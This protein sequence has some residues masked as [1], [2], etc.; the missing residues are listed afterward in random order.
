MKGQPGQLG[1]LGKC[2]EREE[3]DS[4]GLCFH[5]LKHFWH[6]SAISV[7]LVDPVPHICSEK[8]VEMG[9]RT[10]GNKG[11]AEDQV[12]LSF[13]GEFLIV[14]RDLLSLERDTVDQ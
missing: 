4:L 14:F 5:L 1:S 7:S 3:R 11:Q 12:P 10:N 9:V 13:A 6:A 2:L 8:E